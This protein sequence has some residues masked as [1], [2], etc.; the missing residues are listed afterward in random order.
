MELSSTENGAERR[1]MIQANFLEVR[2]MSQFLMRL[3]ICTWGAPLLALTP[4]SESVGAVWVLCVHTLSFLRRL[5]YLY[6]CDI[7][8]IQLLPW[9]GSGHWGNG[10][11]A[12]NNALQ[13]ASN[14]QQQKCFQT[15]SFSNQI[16]F[17]FG[18][19]FE[20]IQSSIQPCLLAC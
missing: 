14:A 10:W 2:D 19:S 16:K 17:F 5:P 18:V 8:A 3:T 1:G 15:K 9:V 13:C 6:F 4:L 20:T 7:V 12:V 11:W